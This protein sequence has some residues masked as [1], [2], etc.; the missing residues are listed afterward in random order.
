MSYLALVCLVNTEHSICNLIVGVCQRIASVFLSIQ[1]MT[2]IILLL[3]RRLVGG[4][5][6]IRMQ[7]VID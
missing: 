5:T 1:C 6:L 2:D 4:V 7:S 3:V